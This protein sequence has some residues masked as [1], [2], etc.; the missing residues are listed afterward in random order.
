MVHIFEFIAGFALAMMVELCWH[1]VVSV[2]LGTPPHIA[3]FFPGRI[4]GGALVHLVALM[5]LILGIAGAGLLVVRLMAGA[6]WQ[7][8]VI[9]AC[10]IMW[11]TYRM[12]Y[13]RVLEI[14]RAQAKTR[15]DG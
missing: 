6:W 14:M 15:L 5:W 4:D 1:G 2:M 13:Y 9:S 12:V 3:R 8:L 7:A 10:T 11:V